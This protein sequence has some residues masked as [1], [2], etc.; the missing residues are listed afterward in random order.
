M[1]KYTRD[2]AVLRAIRTCVCEHAGRDQLAYEPVD[3]EDLRYKLMDLRDEREIVRERGE[4]WR[5]PC[6]TVREI[7]DAGEF[8]ARRHGAFG[9]RKPGARWAVLGPSHQFDTKYS[10]PKCIVVRIRYGKTAMADYEVGIN[11][12]QKAVCWQD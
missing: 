7:L 2:E 4:S 12:D 5:I 6:V 10:R 8:D 11:S 1:H 3:Q 9:D